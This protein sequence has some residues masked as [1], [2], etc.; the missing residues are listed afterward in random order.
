MT[1]IFCRDISSERLETCNKD[2]LT[3]QLWRDIDGQIRISAF[4]NRL[5]GYEHSPS[6]LAPHQT[7]AFQIQIGA[8]DRTDAD[9]KPVRQISVC[10]QSST[11]GY[12]AFGNILRQ[13]SC[14]T[15]M[16]LSSARRQ[17]RNPWR[18]EANGILPKCHAT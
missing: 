8:R 14:N 11:C 2:L 15:V 6:M 13:S 1:E 3:E 7:S 5:D 17:T 9:A 10:R 12:Q 4:T 18:Y 16:Y